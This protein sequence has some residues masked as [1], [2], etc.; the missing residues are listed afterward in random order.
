MKAFESHKTLF[1]S[2]CAWKVLFI[3]ILFSTH[4]AAQKFTATVSKNPVAAN[5]QFKLSYELSANGSSFRPPALNDFLVLSGPNQSTSMQYSNG[6][7]S[8]SITLSYI[9]QPKKEGTFKIEPATIE[10]G[11][12]IIL[13]NMVSVNV[14]KATAQGTQQG[15]QNQ[16]EKSN[17]SSKN[18]FF[19]V[20][21]DKSNVY[22]GEAV[23]ATYKLYTNVQVV[24]YG[25]NKVPSFNGFWTQDMQ[26]PQQLSLDKTETIN[27]ITYRVGE[28]KKVVLFPQQS[29]TLTLEPMEG[30][31]I[32]RIQVKRNRSGSPF[33]I[34]ND[35]FFND[36]F[37]GFG[38]IRDVKFAV[39]S[40]PVKITVKELPGNAPAS[41][42]GAVGRYTLDGTLDKTKLKA[43]DAVSFR[44]KLSGR[45]NIKLIEAPK[46]DLS[47][48]IEKYDPEI[49]DNIT[50]NERGAS[51]TRVF[52]Y[53]MI[54]RH[55]G[56]YEFGPVV[57]SYFDLDKKSYVTLS[58]PK[59]KLDVERGKDGGAA[60][61]VSGKA[62]FQVLGRDIRFIKTTVPV[63]KSERD[64][65]YGTVL[66]WLL[67]AAPFAGFI[68][69]V[70]YRKKQ[71]ADNSDLSAVRSRKATGMA[72]KRLDISSKQL[73]SGNQAGFYDEV[74]RAIWGYI[75]DKLKIPVASLSKD[76]AVDKLKQS[77][78]AS[79]TI[80]SMVAIL[81][82]CEYARFARMEG[83]KS[84]DEV[85][86]ETV[87]VITKV[88]SELK[89]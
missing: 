86:Q 71:L 34:F 67:V 56:Q 29:G 2:G 20:S 66:F 23:V 41:F 26:M 55:Q 38:G 57:F 11:G 28:I 49:T 75:S 45:G 60:T 68:T 48:D 72:R 31:C 6:N 87:S 27:G 85:Y 53:L 15:N 21:I 50:I 73:K 46:F 80:N 37:S 63:F 16:D 83:G 76:V 59:Y 65:F 7:M 82:Y 61:A 58:T 70:A 88:E 35:P 69:L 39:K 40:E 1:F 84:A 30:E 13:S 22:L 3:F 19:K 36:P 17:I 64:D 47:P 44:L 62:D 14:A 54:P 10:S 4:T 25:I 89:A 24:N 18:I 78:V 74:S 79:E 12:K 81:D 33:D 9:L 8:Q 42:N 52:E 5:E 32:A 77:G 51:G 43:N